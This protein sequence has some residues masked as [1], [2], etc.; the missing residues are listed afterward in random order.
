MLP[1]RCTSGASRRFSP[2]RRSAS[3]TKA[4]SARRVVSTDQKQQRRHL[5]HPGGRCYWRSCRTLVVATWALTLHSPTSASR[6]LAS[7]LRFQAAANQSLVAIHQTMAAATLAEASSSC[8]M[9][10]L[11]RRRPREHTRRK[12]R[13]NAAS[14]ARSG[15]VW[16]ACQKRFWRRRHTSQQER[17]SASEPS[18]MH[19]AARESRQRSVFRAGRALWRRATKLLRKPGRRRRRALSATAVYRRPRRR[20]RRRCAQ[21]ATP[22]RG[23]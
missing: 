15:Q 21:K 17:L 3:R 12:P 18:A 14:S 20:Q 10:P 16:Q 8:N 6:Y 1:A 4:S 13:R 23:Q 19:A 22:L 11:C 7:T 5:L 2:R 9:R